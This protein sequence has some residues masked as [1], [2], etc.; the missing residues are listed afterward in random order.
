[1]FPPNHDRCAPS[2]VG[3]MTVMVSRT[4]LG[5]ERTGDTPGVG[6]PTP[7]PGQAGRARQVGSGRARRARGGHAGQADAADAGDVAQVC[8]GDIH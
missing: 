3:R 7:G 8:Q 4:L 5:G 1:M 2:A 6:K